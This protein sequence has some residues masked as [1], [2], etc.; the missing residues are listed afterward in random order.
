MK[1]LC[2]KE[3]KKAKTGNERLGNSA[4]CYLSCL[5]DNGLAAKKQAGRKAERV[6]GPA[7]PSTNCVCLLK[8][9]NFS[10]SV[11]KSLKKELE[12]SEMGEGLKME[13]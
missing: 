3:L 10:G 11:P 4:T 12:T 13:D 5:P 6:R 8:K 7:V 1:K 9:H 2:T